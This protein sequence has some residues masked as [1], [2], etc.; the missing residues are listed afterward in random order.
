MAGGVGI[1]PF[2]AW[3]DSLSAEVPHHIHLVYS[4]RSPADAIR[5]EVLQAAAARNPRSSCEVVA[6]ER[7]GRLTVEGLVRSSP[8]APGSGDLWFC[9]PAGLRRAL[10][11]GLARLGQNPR[12]IRYDY[13][14]FA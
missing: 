11:G 5:L 6:T 8:F 7:D 4:T 10:L 3:A 12:R 13:F 14:D 1:T 9:G 2:L